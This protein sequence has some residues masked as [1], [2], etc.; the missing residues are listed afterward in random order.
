MSV[1]RRL[2]RFYRQDADDAWQGYIGIVVG[3]LVG[4]PVG[5]FGFW[6]GALTLVAVNFVVAIVLLADQKREEG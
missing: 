3:V 5:V 6:L 4:Y 2:V 1:L